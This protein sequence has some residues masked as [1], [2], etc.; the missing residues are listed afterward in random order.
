MGYGPGDIDISWALVL[1]SPLFP[2]CPC[3]PSSSS[4][5]SPFCLSSSSP[6]MMHGVCHRSVFMVGFWGYSSLW[7][8][9]G[10]HSLS[11]SEPTVIHLHYPTCKQML[12]AVGIGGGQRCHKILFWGCER[13]FMGVAGY[14]MGE[15]PPSRVSLHSSAPS[16]AVLTPSHPV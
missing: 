5:S 7:R 4:L 2:C 9:P 11:L 12:T 16:Q 15:Y 8:G 10:A 13:M 14:F 6:L 3:L 1:A